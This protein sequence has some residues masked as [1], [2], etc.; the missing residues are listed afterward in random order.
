MVSVPRLS[1]LWANNDSKNYYDLL[2]K[3]SSLFLSLCFPCCIGVA[4]LAPEI[5]YIYA[6]EKFFSGN[7][8]LFLFAIYNFIGTFDTIYSKQVL[9]AT[10]NE[11]SLTRIYYTGGI[12]NLIFKKDSTNSEV[13]FIT[14]LDVEKTK[15][16]LSDFFKKQRK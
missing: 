1:Y 11:A 15:K 3:S 14:N 4:I 9:L 16:I 5:L 7:M 6:G 13:N 12:L 8:V 10:G 2:Q